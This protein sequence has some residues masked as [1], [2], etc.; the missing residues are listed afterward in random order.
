MALSRITFE[1]CE[2]VSASFSIG[3]GKSNTSVNLQ[4]VETIVAGQNPSSFVGYTGELGKIYSITVDNVFF[5]GLLTNHSI[6]VGASGRSIS[7]TLTDGRDTLENI[8]IITGRQYGVD[9]IYLSCDSGQNILSAL[10]SLEP[11]SSSQFLTASNCGGYSTEKCSSTAGFGASYRDKH[12]IPSRNVIAL[13]VTAPQVIKLPLSNQTI[14][15]DLSNLQSALTSTVKGFYS[16]IDSNSLS[17]MELIQSVCDDIAADF[18][19]RLTAGTVG[20]SDFNIVVDVINRQQ[21][22]T[23]FALRDY[24]NDN[25][26]NFNLTKELDYG[27]ESTNVTT[28]KV[29]M[30]DNYRYFL[31]IHDYNRGNICFRS[32]VQSGPFLNDWDSGFGNNAISITPDVTPD[33]I[34][35]I[36]DHEEHRV[37]ATPDIYLDTVGKDNDLDGLSF[38]AQDVYQGETGGDNGTQTS[39]VDLVRLDRNINNQGNDPGP[40]LQPNDCLLPNRHRIFQILGEDTIQI[41]NENNV[42]FPPVQKIHLTRYGSEE[43]VNGFDIDWKPN[44]KVLLQ[45]LQLTSEPLDDQAGRYKLYAEDLFAIWKPR[46]TLEELLASSNYDTYTKW[47]ANHKNSVGYFCAIIL[48]DG[49]ENMSDKIVMGLMDTFQKGETLDPGAYPCIT[50]RN[51]KQLELVQMHVKK[52]YDDYYGKEFAVLLDR[53]LL[54]H[55]RDAGI[56]SNLNSH[57]VCF[58]S[59]YNTTLAQ[60]IV[61]NQFPVVP[62]TKLIPPNSP[63]SD[64]NEGYIY[65]YRISGDENN[66]DTS[67]T[68]TNGGWASGPSQTGVMGIP[69]RTLNKFQNTDGT[70]AGF[71]NLGPAKVQCAQLGHLWG[72]YKPELSNL[73]H[74]QF[75][76][77]PGDQEAPNMRADNCIGPPLEEVTAVNP[78]T[79]TDH[80]D[81]AFNV[82][83]D[84][85]DD[86]FVKAQFHPEMIFARLDDASILDYESGGDAVLVRFSIP[87]V[88]LTQEAIVVNNEDF[89]PAEVFHNME[90]FLTGT[91]VTLKDKDQDPRK[92]PVGDKDIDSKNPDAVDAEEVDDDKNKKTDGAISSAET[93]KYSDF[94]PLSCVP[95]E[96]CI[97]FL[98]NT[99]VYGPFSVTADTDGGTEI[100][101][102]DLAPWQFVS[103]L[104]AP[105]IVPI[106]WTNGMV[107]AGQ[108]IAIDGVNSRVFQEKASVSMVGTPTFD[109]SSD[110]AVVADSFGNFGAIIDSLNISYGSNGA[111]T[112]VSFS[113]YT[114]KFG[115]TEEYVR[116]SVQSLVKE[117]RQ[118]LK[119]ITSDQ[120]K[121]SDI[122]FKN[123]LKIPKA[124]VAKKKGGSSDGSP[125]MADDGSPSDGGVSTKAGTPTARFNNSAEDGNRGGGAET[126]VSHYGLQRGKA[127]KNSDEGSDVVTDLKVTEI[128]TKVDDAPLSI[129]KKPTASDEGNIVKRVVRTQISNAY[130]QDYNQQYYRNM[131]MTSLD[132]HF[133]PVSISGGFGGK[134]EGNLQSFVNTLSSCV[135]GMRNRPYSSIPP[136]KI[137]SIEVTDSEGNTNDTFFDLQICSNYLNP[138][139]TKK[140]M[141]DRLDDRTNES[142]VGFNVGKIAVD[143]DPQYFT[144]IDKVV[145]RKDTS[146]VVEDIYEED[147]VTP[148]ANVEVEFDRQEQQDFRFNAIRGPLVLQGWGYDTDGKPIPN[149]NDSAKNCEKGKFRD[150]GLKDKFLKNW[151]SNPKTWPVAPIDLRFDRNRGVWVAPTHSKVLLARMKE[152]LTPNSQA[153]AELFNGSAGNTDDKV[154]YYKDT[155]LWGPDGEDIRQDVRNATVIVYDYLGMTVSKGAFAYLYYDDGKYIVINQKSAGG[156]GGA[157]IPARTISGAGT[158]GTFTAEVVDA[159]GN[160]E[161]TDDR[162]NE[163]VVTDYL[164]IIPYSIPQ[165]TPITIADIGES[166]SCV[167][168]V[169]VPKGAVGFNSSVGGLLFDALPL[170]SQVP[171]YFIGMNGSNLVKYAGVATCDEVIS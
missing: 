143:K 55:L 81:V 32:H 129:T 68:P 86:I 126:V 150:T 65:G 60:S 74:D 24:V 136:L 171:T 133:L 22:P 117:R 13:F 28:R 151:L 16:I 145:K 45:G 122:S 96:V 130:S 3:I 12:G 53:Q 168:S 48:I 163:V 90:L 114:R 104:Q 14:R 47:I 107:R 41:P 147:G 75:L 31:Q 23:A 33:D 49:W 160:F 153:E 34:I 44:A 25:F 11:G 69:W 36:V 70:I 29:V 71:V 78:R 39:N 2:V 132:A 124:K 54:S 93:I 64:L 89:N 35:T 119:K 155:N 169:G 66:F 59:S 15:I 94:N 146:I 149:D 170:A 19:I 4:L 83:G 40:D 17:I 156:G 88:D 98:S 100:V 57:D 158:G 108:N 139:M 105:N 101:E 7:V 141:D 116:E 9:G 128:S 77:H 113:S 112:D 56:S 154:A 115:Q 95:C 142:A 135:S 157:V 144:R 127:D 61:D 159:G 152:N 18:N 97:P 109:L 46:L 42:R 76:F 162:D 38:K 58:N 87:K 10:R 43:N 1:G 125:G 103:N 52:I 30:G 27:Q 120:D 51:K 164:N 73:N 50:K 138:Y 5:I 165:D 26:A 111:S 161:L 148:T 37:D 102:T 63:V 134:D 131:A 137:T 79:P 67:D 82:I 6:K 106:S 166:N 85:F 80:D 167:V 84:P 99:Q 92:K 21:V 62:S 91:T 140:V 72:K 20:I 118:T 110:S 8:Q 121:K 123:S